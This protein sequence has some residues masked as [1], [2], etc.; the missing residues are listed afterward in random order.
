[1]ITCDVET[2]LDR[3]TIISFR[4]VADFEEKIR[5]AVAI[6]RII[7]NSGTHTHIRVRTYTRS[8]I[9]S[10]FLWNYDDP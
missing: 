10:H 9:L 2:N 4:F 1:M 3:K 6:Q 8:S 7:E 5:F